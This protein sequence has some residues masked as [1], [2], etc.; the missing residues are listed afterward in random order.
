MR[1]FLLVSQTIG[2]ALVLSGSQAAFANKLVHVV[3]ELSPNVDTKTVLLTGATQ[4][5]EAFP[6]TVVPT[7]LL[8]YMAGIKTAFAITIGV[9]GGALFFLPFAGWQQLGSTAQRDPDMDKEPRVYM[10]GA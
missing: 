4:I 3:Q 7:I 10:H 2:S 1:A 8:G 6:P 9:T 5:R